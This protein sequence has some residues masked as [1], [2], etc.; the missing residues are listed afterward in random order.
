MTDTW[1]ANRRVSGSW[2]LVLTA[3]HKVT[4]FRLNSGRRTMSEQWYFYTHQPPPAAYPNANAPHIRVGSE[5]HALDIASTDGG[6]YRLAAV[7][8][9][10]G[11]YPRWTV[12]GE[13]WHIE[14]TAPELATLTKR[15]RSPGPRTL[16][17]GAHGA[18]VKRLQRILRAR[19]FKT[20]PAPGKRGHGYYGRTSRSAVRRIQR[21]HG[22]T[23]D[24]VVGPKTWQLLLKE[25]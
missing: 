18:T 13:S 9:R 5:A 19:G 8:R 12:P 24:G 14:V 23:V 11:A 22:L 10:W 4:S 15:F 6:V 17:R 2:A 7:L 20:V 3:A 16:R 25:T 1:Y 21:K